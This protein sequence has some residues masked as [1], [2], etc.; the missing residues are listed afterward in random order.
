MNFKIYMGQKLDPGAR[1]SGLKNLRIDPY[2]PKRP[3]I[4]VVATSMFRSLDFASNSMM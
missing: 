2:L 3:R 1:E 4:S